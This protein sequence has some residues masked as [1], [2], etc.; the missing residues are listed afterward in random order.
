MVSSTIHSLSSSFFEFLFDLS[1]EYITYVSDAGREGRNWPKGRKGIMSLT[2]L[3]IQYTQT[4]E[5]E[6]RETTKF[7]SFGNKYGKAARE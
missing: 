5:R 7:G 4:A 1:R 2:P 6:R 3:A